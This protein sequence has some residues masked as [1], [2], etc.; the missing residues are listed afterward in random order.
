MDH[1]ELANHLVPNT[2]DETKGPIFTARRVAQE[3]KSPDVIAEEVGVSRPTVDRHLGPLVDLNLATKEFDCYRL[4]PAGRVICAALETCMSSIGIEPTDFVTRT[5]RRIQILS[6]LS[7]ESLQFTHVSDFPTETI[8][9]PTV[10]R[11][12]SDLQ[13]REWVERD[14][15]GIYRL[16]NEGPRIEQHL[17]ALLIEFE[18]IIDKTAFVNRLDHHA[19][20]FPVEALAAV[21]IVHPTPDEAHAALSSLLKW[22]PE[23]VDEIRTICPTFSPVM[24][25]AFAPRLPKNAKIQ[26]SF[27]QQTFRE[28]CHPQNLQYL[29]GSVLLPNVDVRVVPEDLKIGIGIYSEC[30][31]HS[32]SVNT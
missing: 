12:L 22:L 28:L 2:Q 8:P 3:R 10:R 23:T 13:A 9:E 19:I 15:N 4:N 16:T 29:A 1:I 7:D 24:F 26:I 14:S 5:P 21:D 30:V 32:Y 31:M 25:E 17:T 18:Q 27:D 6:L 11:T 20:D